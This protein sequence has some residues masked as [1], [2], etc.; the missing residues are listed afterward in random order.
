MRETNSIFCRS[1]LLCALLSFAVCLVSR[2]LFDSPLE[3]LHIVKGVKLLPP[4]WFF[5]LLS[6]AWF[7]LIGL[8]AGAI[9]DKTSLRL[10]NGNN[11]ICAYKGGIYFSF[12][13][14]LGIIIYHVFFI[15]RM[16]LLS[17]F[18]SAMC[19]ICTF[20]CAVTWRKVRPMTSSFIMFCFGGWNF[21]LFFVC[22]SVFLN[23]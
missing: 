10:N 13:F 8:S 2:V 16:L 1:S 4:L 14:F 23:N 6:Y 21:Y 19:M 7:F 18:I 15:L 22:L 5:N 11:E 3:M 9:I 20:L 12:S 17:T